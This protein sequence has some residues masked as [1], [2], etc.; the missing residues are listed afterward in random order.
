LETAASISDR[1]PRFTHAIFKKLSSFCCL[2]ESSSPALPLPAPDATAAAIE[3]S[4]HTAFVVKNNDVAGYKQQLLLLLRAL[5]CPP[6]APDDG[7]FVA[8]VVRHAI[9]ADEIASMVAEDMVS[10]AAAAAASA[11]R[12]H[13]LHMASLAPEAVE[14]GKVVNTHVHSFWSYPKDGD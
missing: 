14:L 10:V 5:H 3:S 8:R 11:L 9:S 4:L 12:Q 2:A 13:E 6:G 7:S 1:R